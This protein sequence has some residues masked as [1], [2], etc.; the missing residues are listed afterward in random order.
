MSSVNDLILEE[1]WNGEI[2]VEFNVLDCD[3]AAIERPFPCNVL[4]PRISYLPVHCGE[5]VDYFHSKALELSSDI[6][7]EF[8]GRMLNCT[9]PIGLLYDFYVG[10]GSVDGPWKINIRFQGGPLLTSQQSISSNSKFSEKMYFHLLKQSL[11][12]LHGSSRM[13]N[14][15]SIEQ[16]GALWKSISSKNHTQFHTILSGVQYSDSPPKNIPIRLVEV[17]TSGDGLQ[18]RQKSVHSSKETGNQRTCGEIL[19]DDFHYQ[20]SVSEVMIHGVAVPT[21]APICSLWEV[22]KYGDLFLYIIVRR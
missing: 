22:M 18:V 12:I 5:I 19:Q 16:Q 10:D 8:D 2:R 13:F 4:L 14:N 21:E 17:G 7:Y 6:W 20:A 3:I 9:L 15:L 1:L 11:H